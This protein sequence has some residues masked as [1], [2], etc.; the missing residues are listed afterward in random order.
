MKT[1]LPGGT[2]PGRSVRSTQRARALIL[3]ERLEH[4]REGSVAAARA[5]EES[6]VPLLPHG[7]ASRQLAAAFHPCACLLK[8]LISTAGSGE[9]SRPD[10]CAVSASLQ[11]CNNIHRQRQG[12]WSASCVFITMCLFSFYLEVSQSNQSW[13]TLPSSVQPGLCRRVWH[14]WFYQA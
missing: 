9:D 5:P 3:T 2:F 7:E 6:P 12:L 10:S 1:H 11:A 8:R 13:K 14:L 4:P